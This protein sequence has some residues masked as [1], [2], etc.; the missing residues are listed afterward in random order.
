MVP[1]YV[2][3]KIVP[4]AVILDPH[5]QSNQYHYEES[6]GSGAGSGSDPHTNGSGSENPQNTG[7][8]R[9]RIP[10]HCRVV[11]SEPPFTV[12][13]FPS[14]WRTRWSTGWSGP[15]PRPPSIS[16]LWTRPLH[17][18]RPPHPPP[19]PPSLFTCI[20]SYGPPPICPP[21]AGGGG[22]EI[23]CFKN[24][25]KRRCSPIEAFY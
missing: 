15:A 13:N 21:P 9:I 11:I 24:C 18:Q 22:E 17:P 1:T 10:T 5:F 8:L 7:L 19:V 23:F 12:K 3:Q 20:W 16:C 14:R 2:F 4:R 6:E 25:D